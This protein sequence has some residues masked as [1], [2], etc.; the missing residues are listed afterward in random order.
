[1]TKIDNFTK[2]EFE[3]IVKNSHTFSEIYWRWMGIGIIKIN[4]FIKRCI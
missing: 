4:Y 1:M 3:E 2:E